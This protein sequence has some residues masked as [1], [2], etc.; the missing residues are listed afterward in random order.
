MIPNMSPRPGPEDYGHDPGRDELIIWTVATI[1]A[2][3]LVSVVMW[4][5]G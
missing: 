1:F 5:V 4:W 3:A 2:F